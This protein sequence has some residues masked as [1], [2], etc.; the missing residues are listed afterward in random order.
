MDGGYGDGDGGY[1]NGGYG[2]GDGGHMDGGYGDGDGGYSDDAYRD[3]DGGFSDDEYGDAACAPP[4]LPQLLAA[5]PLR[6]CIGGDGRARVLWGVE[7]HE[8]VGAR[9][10]GEAAGGSGGTDQQ[11]GSSRD[12]DTGCPDDEA[13]LMQMLPDR[14]AKRVRVCVHAC[15]MCACVCRC[16]RAFACLGMAGAAPA[17]LVLST[18]GRV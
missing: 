13:S 18:H 9:G 15:G 7:A 6:L 10:A 14:W 4:S 1:I 11:G 3:G 2:D 8:E 17:V 5:G 12:A 16:V